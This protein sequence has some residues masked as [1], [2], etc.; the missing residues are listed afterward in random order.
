MLICWVW[1]LEAFYLVHIVTNINTLRGWHSLLP[2]QSQNSPK[3]QSEKHRIIHS[4]FNV[5]VTILELRKSMS[6][7]NNSFLPLVC[8]HLVDRLF[9]QKKGLPKIPHVGE[10]MYILINH[11]GGSYI[12]IIG[13]RRWRWSGLMDGWMDPTYVGCHFLSCTFNLKVRSGYVAV[14]VCLCMWVCVCVCVWL[15]SWLCD[16]GWHYE[17]V[18]PMEDQRV[19]LSSRTL[20]ILI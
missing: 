10:L 15:F 4:T 7:S 18:S 11:D 17:I 1:W 13:Q 6:K 8:V 9:L 19:N 16:F 5:Y 3:S 20:Q 2:P 14:S 12:L